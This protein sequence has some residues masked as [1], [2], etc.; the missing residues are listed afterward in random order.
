MK[1]PIS[2]NIRLYTTNLLMKDIS[3]KIT[4]DD[5]HYLKKVMRVSFDEELLIFNGIDGEWKSKVIGINRDYIELKIINKIREQ[6]N[7]D[8]FECFF[9]PLKSNRHNYIIEKLT[10]LGILS[11][12]PILT[13]YCNIRKINQSKM[14]LRAK[15]AAEQ[16]GIL[17]VPTVNKMI[18]F[19]DLLKIDYMHEP[20]IFFDENC[21][22]Q[23]PLS[24]IKSLNKGKVYFLIGPE[25]GFSDIE[26]DNILK[27]NNV[28]RMSLGS[29]ILRADTA[30]IVAASMIQIT[31]GNMYNKEKIST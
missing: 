27:L 21:Q 17:K 24:M 25:G 1:N 16:C 30:A 28:I 31:I 29:R 26:R 18:N 19:N 5:C 4:N 14:S 2:R 11:F 13:D 9:T 23:N 15:E 20:L 22:I 7:Y 6:I 3:I 12:T 10:E 8:N